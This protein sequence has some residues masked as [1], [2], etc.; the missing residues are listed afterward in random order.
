M[1]QS[2]QTR[3]SRR[4]ALK[5]AGSAGAMLA[6]PTVLPSTVFGQNAPSN[7]VTVGMVGAGRQA[8]IVNIK[9]MLNMNDVQIVAVCDVDRWRLDN[10]K[11][12]VDEKYGDTGCK[13]YTDWREV[14]A[15]DDIDAIMNSTPDH[16]HVPISLAAVRCGKHVSCEKPLT[17]S[18][19]EGR[20]L[21]DAVKKHGVV[22]R[23]DSECRSH[24]FMHK[25]AELVRNGYIGKIKRFEVGVPAGDVAGGNPEP[26]PVPEELNY[27]M[28]MGPIAEKPYTVDAVHPPKGYGR[29]GWMRCRDTCEGMITNWGTHLIDVAQLVNNSERTGPVSVE[30]TGQYPEPGSGL[31]N[32][33]LDFRVQY[34]YAGGIPM[35]YII[36]KAGAYLRVEGEEGWLQANWFRPGGFQAS[37]PALLEIELKDSDLHIP[38]RED[39]E[40]FIYCIK[41]NAPD[42]SMADAEVGHRTCSIGQL[43]HIA[44]QC[45][46]KLEWD[47]A[48]ERFTN[49]DQA[50]EM[51]TKDYR[52]PWDLKIAIGSVG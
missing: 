42:Q 15:R 1:N 18:I 28:W 13:A 22:F 25:T 35:D 27:D 39:K 8:A 46:G 7:R 38:R 48:K 2:N 29:P 44:I 11:K 12:A 24:P 20:A 17:L 45:G 3:I 23:T 26:M 9:N 16:W 21:A 41:N 4:Q 43:A 52:Q 37:D 5:Y 49:S 10:A 50:N 47:P 19:A 31:W 33:L 34:Q 30:G 36:D 40:D 51:L 14:L 6:F 32:V